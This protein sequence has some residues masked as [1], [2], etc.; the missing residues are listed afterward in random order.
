MTNKFNIH[1]IYSWGVHFTWFGCNKLVERNEN[2]LKL[3]NWCK[4]IY[5]Q[6]T[7]KT[8]C[9]RRT[10]SFLNLKTWNFR[11]N[12]CMHKNNGTHTC[13][14]TCNFV[15]ALSSIVHRKL[16]GNRC[17]CQFQ[18]EFYWGENWYDLWPHQLSPQGHNLIV[19]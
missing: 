7:K 15:K 13:T 5:K 19:N 2:S 1:I 6:N 4:W 10:L 14:K 17:L 3:T 8:T 9:K 12:M 16:T 11:K 18:S